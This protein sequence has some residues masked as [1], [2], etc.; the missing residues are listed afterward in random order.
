MS[1][2]DENNLRPPRA[3]EPHGR[4]AGGQNDP[5]A[6]LARLIGQDDPFKDLKKNPSARREPASSPRVEAPS[7]APGWLSRPGS[8]E[9]T[10]PATDRHS[11]VPH[12]RDARF[13]DPHHTNYEPGDPYRADVD[14]AADSYAPDQNFENDPY[15]EEVPAD[16]EH[17]YD[18]QPARRRGGLITLV[19]VVAMA[20]IGT[21]GVF[22]YRAFT[23]SSAGSAQPQVIKAD[24]QPTKVAPAP[25]TTDAQANK[26][27][28]DRIGDK[29]Q[30]EKL[31]SREE[32][33]VDPSAR[34][35]LPP[36]GA[37]TAAPPT[38]APVVS[39]AEPKKVK[40]VPI[41][42]EGAQA[43]ARPGM[44]PTALAANPQKTAPTAR[45][46]AG[47]TPMN[48]GSQTQTASIPPRAPAAEG[49]YVVQVASQ[50]SEADAQASYRSLQAKY[51]A[52]LGPRQ[53]IIRRAELGDRGTF[54]RAQVGPFASIEQANELCTSLKTAGGQCVVQKN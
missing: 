9:Q 43:P 16:G 32:Q 39:G 13:V 53:A 35:A 38:P 44:P 24:T 54:Y 21:G 49:G 2:V 11:I 28:Y 14:A 20:L 18:E 47:N 4:T 50:R 5:L 45:P 42:P 48:L 17:V 19:V 41:R 25:Q 37:T 33:P 15:Y 30:G 34:G 36:I 10:L 40:T 31:V 3:D 23:G 1:M 46:S 26:S 22:A 52:V 51:P 6:E 12:E 7:T 8:G 29:A 27:I